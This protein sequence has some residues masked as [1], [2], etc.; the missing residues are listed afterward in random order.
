MKR[1]NRQMRGLALA[2]IAL[3]IGMAAPV[4]ALD[5]VVRGRDLM[6][7]EEWQQHSSLMRTM[8]SGSERAKYRAAIHAQMQQRAAE[9]GVQLIGASGPPGRGQG[10]GVPRAVSGGYG[11]PAGCVARRCLQ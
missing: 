9:Q 11:C 8:A 7:A 2:A 1:A 10:H 6:T 4:H 3:G 5:E